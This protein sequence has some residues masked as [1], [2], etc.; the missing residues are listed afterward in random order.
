MN[1]LI[2]GPPGAGKGT[3]AARI[4]AQREIPHIS[5]GEMLR[6]AVGSGSELGLRV[7]KII[8]RGH[9]VSDEVMGELVA[10]RLAE[11][12]ARGGFL[13]DGFPRTVAQVEILDQ[14]LGNARRIDSVLML[15]V[16]DRE[17]VE[18]LLRRATIEG[19]KDDNRETIE[20]RLRVYRARTEPVAGVYQK[21]GLLRTIDGTGSIE[22]VFARI[23]AVLDRTAAEGA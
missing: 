4:S 21:R 14:V 13:L 22:E 12:D 20:E 8:E 10:Q 18:R 16:P 1:L 5:T 2:F 11:K 17:L 6:V 7:K 23:E 15:D 3:Q 19:R 9:L